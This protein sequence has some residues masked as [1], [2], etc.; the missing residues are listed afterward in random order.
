M[1]DV[2][3]RYTDP[4]QPGAPEARAKK[5]EALLCSVGC[6]MARQ[7]RGECL[8]PIDDE[9]PP[10]ARNTDPETSHQAA[11]SMHGGA[12]GHRASIL[13]LLGQRGPM[14]GDQIDEA[15]GWRVTSAGRRLCEL[16]AMGLVER[17]EDVAPTRSGR[18]AGVYKLRV[19]S[20]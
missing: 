3:P 10:R 2:I 9:P 7:H 1:T 12:K 14:N 8:V 6:I 5:A 11:R 13:G 17:T 18:K 19:E 15:M 4:G 20:S 16:V